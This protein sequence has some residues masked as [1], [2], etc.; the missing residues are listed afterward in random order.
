MTGQT[1]SRPMKQ[2]H[3][4]VFSAL[5][6]EYRPHVWRMARHF[7]VPREQLDDVTQEVWVSAL[8]QLEGL[9]LSHPLK[10]WLT[11]VVWNHV[12]H[13]R[14]GNARRLRKGQALADT[15]TD[16]DGRAEPAARTEA[17]WELERLLADLPADQ[18]EVLLLC[19]GEGL[20]APEVSEAL[21]V[22]LNTVYSRLRLARRRCQALAASLGAAAWALML[23]RHT[24]SGPDAPHIA[25]ALT[26]APDPALAGS[27]ATAASAGS[28][29]H[30]W[31]YV[32]VTAAAVVALGLGLRARED[33]DVATEPPVIAQV[34][35]PATP[36]PEVEAQPEVEAPG[37][38]TPEPTTVTP[39]AS[40]PPATKRRPARKQAAITPA[41]EAPQPAAPRKIDGLGAEHRIIEQ[42]RAALAQG[43]VSQALALLAEHRRDFPSGASAYTRELLRYEAYC[44]RGDTRRALEVAAQYPKDRTFRELA[45]DACESLRAR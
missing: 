5:Y 12:R 8:K 4:A 19:D 39:P 32:A 42:A 11:T 20:S 1:D 34:D 15:T 13:L 31:I 33:H 21:G 16:D 26:R 40:D 29:I 28:A 25:A 38:V 2:Q 14:R 18:R 17:A 10:P 7:G 35:P 43:T 37:E 24:A 44:L 30:P 27:T 45:A 41:P 22:Q 3:D 9:D 23:Q 36:M 6:D